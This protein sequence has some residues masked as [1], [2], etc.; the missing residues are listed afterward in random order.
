MYCIVI[1]SPVNVFKMS[2]KKEMTKGTKGRLE[3]R[4]RTTILRIFPRGPLG[5]LPRSFAIFFRLLIFGVFS[6]RCGF[7]KRRAFVF[8]LSLLN[9]CTV[10][11]KNLETKV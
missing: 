9:C 1:P 8:C 5:L 7:T 4:S 2:V 3:L 10:R 11:M 6:E